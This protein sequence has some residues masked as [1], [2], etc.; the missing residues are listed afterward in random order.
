MLRG[1]HECRAITEHFT[2]RKEILDKYLLPHVGL[3]EEDRMAK[4]K[5]LCRTT[6]APG[7][8]YSASRALAEFRLNSPRPRSALD[9]ITFSPRLRGAPPVFMLQPANRTDPC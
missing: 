6:S 8:K 5:N 4:V 7:D 9:K 1:N 2:F 3:Q